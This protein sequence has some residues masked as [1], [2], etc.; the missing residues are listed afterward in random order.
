MLFLQVNK[1]LSPQ[2]SRSEGEIF[3]RIK[4]GISFPLYMLVKNDMKHLEIDSEHS[5]F[6]LSAFS[7]ATL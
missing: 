4:V 1:K 7:H 3:E 2:Y 5:S 6:G